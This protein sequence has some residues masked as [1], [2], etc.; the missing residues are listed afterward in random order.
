MT[1]LYN[2][3]TSETVVNNGASITGVEPA[4]STDGDR[5]LGIYMGG[6]NLTMT[7]PTGWTEEV[8]LVESLGGDRQVW[9]GYIDRGAS[10]PDLTW[11]ISGGSQDNHVTIFRLPA[12]SYID[13]VAD[14]FR[15][16][17]VVGNSD[18]GGDVDCTV[19]ALVTTK[20]TDLVIAAGV[21]RD[22]SGVHT[23][24]TAPTGFTEVDT[25]VNNGSTASTF[26]VAKHDGTAN[27]S[28]VSFS[29]TGAA[30]GDDGTALLLVIG[31]ILDDEVLCLVDDDTS[32]TTDEQAV[33]DLIE[34]MGWQTVAQ[35]F[36]DAEVTSGYAGQAY[37]RPYGVSDNTY[38]GDNFA[39]L[40]VPALDGASD[41][42]ARGL[43]MTTGVAQA[44]LNNTLAQYNDSDNVALEGQSD[45]DNI[46]VQTNG[47]MRYHNNG[48]VGAL[49]ARN[50][51]HTVTTSR[52]T[53]LTHAAGLTDYGI[54]ATG[55]MDHNAAS[56]CWVYGIQ[57][58]T[59]TDT[60]K[61]YV[62]DL[63]EWLWPPTA[64]STLE[65]DAVG[66]ASTVAFGSMAFEFDQEYDATGIPS[67]EAFGTLDLTVAAI[68]YNAT[69]IASTV[70]FGTL[71]LTEGAADYD[72]VGIP[73]G[74]AFGA[75]DLTAGVID[76]DAVGIPSGVAF[77]SMAFG[78]SAIEYSAV[79][80]AST[81]AFGTAAL[82]EGVAALNPTGIA[83]TV[84]F[85]S[86]SFQGG[87]ATL[88]PT[89]IAS[90]VAFGTLDLTA[91]AVDLNAVGIASTTA[92]GT[93]AFGSQ[94]LELNPTGIASTVQFGAVSLTPG[95]VS[96]N[97]TGIAS[98]VAFGTMSFAGGQLLMFVGIPSS[99]AF[100]G[101]DL[102]TQVRLMVAS[103]AHLDTRT[104]TDAVLVE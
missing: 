30:A 65:F 48:A 27:Y 69:G 60:A 85:G 72:A 94:A 19:G 20:E 41:Y 35:T 2:T 22:G 95:A 96:L 88:N 18:A 66:I 64:S 63:F 13:T 53:V 49:V 102:Q 70:A 39:G 84:A 45:G 89:G 82:T 3:A 40:D 83:S 29:V 47:R 93:M 42:G 81:V 78:E 59:L 7:S 38:I 71:D 31:S 73:S 25:D 97:P 52:H 68:D 46:T 90:T 79:G 8:S 67:G 76:F 34:S 43:R 61:H 23:A 51:H 56:L 91:G 50:F 101:L 9:A 92:F 87:A 28:D 62:N 6:E 33:I 104:D 37:A 12:G 5:L 100:G 11:D 16:S 44:G 54:N 99:L 32:I 103:T 80:I 24:V 36:T 26:H 1:L 4:G 57:Q 58:G 14:M 74:T 75:V 98:T 86:M 55:T 17:G 77:G 10:A 15:F 21:L